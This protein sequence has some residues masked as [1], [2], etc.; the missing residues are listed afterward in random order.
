MGSDDCIKRLVESFDSQFGMQLNEGNLE[1]ASFLCLYFIWRRDVNLGKMT[2]RIDA[3][4]LAAQSF[5]LVSFLLLIEDLIHA[6]IG[7]QLYYSEFVWAACLLLCLLASASAFNYHRK[8]RLY[9]R[10]QIYLATV[11]ESEKRLF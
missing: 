2:T 1:P 5:V 4:R 6:V 7:G 9:A 8:K 3:E 11:R 10:F